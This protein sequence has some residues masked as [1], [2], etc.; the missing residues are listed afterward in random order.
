MP[1]QVL[2]DRQEA[3]ASTGAF[4][5]EVRLWPHQS[6][7]GTG[8]VWIIGGTFVMACIP[9]LGLLGTVVFLGI[10]P[11]AMISVLALTWSLKRNWRDRD[12]VETFRLTHDRVEL[13]RIDPDGS[14]R[15]WEANPYWIRV[16]RHDKVGQVEDY[17]TLDGGPRRVEIGAFL[18]PAERRGLE[19]RL[20]GALARLR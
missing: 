1:Y 6:L 2:T 8:F 9:L 5:Y 18:T 20:A 19:D 14:R 10:L 4:L 11:F 17:L 3:P 16:S 7:T 12:I 13:I 15:D